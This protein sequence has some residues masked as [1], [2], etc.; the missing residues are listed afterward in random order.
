MNRA[1]RPTPL[2][3]YE[4]ACALHILP[5]NRQLLLAKASIWD[6]ARTLLATNAEYYKFFEY[7]GFGKGIPLTQMINSGRSLGDNRVE[8]RTLSLALRTRVVADSDVLVIAADAAP[9]SG[10]DVLAVLNSARERGCSALV[11]QTGGG[12]TAAAAAATCAAAP[13]CVVTFAYDGIENVSLTT[14]DLDARTGVAEVTS[15]SRRAFSPIFYALSA[16]DVSLLLSPVGD[17]A[18]AAC[19]TVPSSTLE[20]V[21]VPVE[22]AVRVLASRGRLVSV[23]SPP[24][25]RGALNGKPPVPPIASPPSPFAHALPAALSSAPLGDVV[26]ATGHARVGLLGNPSDGY[27]GKTMSVTIANFKAEAW[28][29]PTLG[30]S[31][32]VLIP[33][34]VYDPVVVPSLRALSVIAQRE[35]YGGGIRLMSATLNRFYQWFEK[36]QIVLPDTPGFSLRYHTTVP[37]QVGLAGSSAIVTALVRALLRFYGYADEA[38]AAAVGLSKD[39]LPNF[40]L[41]IESEELGITA[42]LQDRVVQ[43]YEGPVHM[44]F[45]PELLAAQGF[46]TYTRVAASALPPLFLA[47]AADPSDSGKIHAPIKQRWLSGDVAVIDAMKDIASNADAA[48]AVATARP[49]SAAPTA[50]AREAIASEWA[51]LFTRNFDGRRSLFGDPALGRDNIR[52][53]EI[54]REVGAAAKLPGSGG[55]VVGVVDVAGVEAAGWPGVNAR[56]PPAPGADA[57]AASHNAVGNVRVAAAAEALRVAYHKE[58]YVFIRITPF[59]RGT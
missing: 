57:P 3:S 27:G 28:V 33:H 6:P 32:I 37:R 39:T 14:I 47:Y 46:G 15:A 22:A 35:G 54:A 44:D 8:W 13:A 45:S 56:P 20:E 59:E 2:P 43:S 9:P 17:A 48:K 1:P 58:G 10:F 24:W 31:G 26:Y 30:R 50:S 53:I 7:W 11:T 25:P 40:V 52:M 4:L 42:G 12:A 16:A 41:A 19:A 38:A 36:R 51:T 23:E 5:L 18:L 21:I 34:P 49:Y 29:T 55:A